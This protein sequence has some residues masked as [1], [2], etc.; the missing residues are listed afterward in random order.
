MKKQLLATLVTGALAAISVQPVSANNQM[1]PMIVVGTTPS[2]SENNLAG[3][4][5]SIS[6]DELAISHVDDTMELF[7]KVPGVY[8]ARYNQGIIN[9]D[10][11][12]RGFAAEGSTPHAK[13]LIDGIPANLHNGYSEMDQLFPANIDSVQVFK[14][15][16]DPRYGLHNVAGNYTI[17]TRTDLAREVELTYGSFNA[18]EVQAYAGEQT[19]NLQHSYFIGY[20][21]ADGYRDNE[22]LEKISA[23]GRWFYDFT[24][25]TRI[26]FIARV[27]EYDADAAGY[28]SREEARKHPTRSADYARLDG[29]D[30]QTQSFSLHFDHA[31]SDQLDWSVK[32][33]FNHYERE[34]WVRF[35]E[36]SDLQNRYD[37][38]DQYGVISTLNWQ[39]HPD[40]EVQWGVDAERQD[41]IEQRF[42]TVGFQRQRDS[43][44]VGRDYDYRFVSYGSYL[45]VSHMPVD[46]LAWNVALRG[47]RIRGEFTSTDSAGQKEQRNIY[48]FGTIVQPKAN[49]FLYPTDDV[50]LFVNVGRSFQHPLGASAYT[51]GNTSAR[52]V[53]L[54]DGW[55]AGVKW[56]LF[57]AL[58]L[59]ASYWEQKA[60]DEF[61]MIDGV[62]RNVGETLREGID[63]GFDWDLT[64]KVT[65]WGNIAGVDTEIQADGANKGNELRS[66]PDYTASLGLSYLI[67]PELTWRVHLD[68]QSGSY[69]NEENIGGQYGHYNLVNTSLDYLTDWGNINLQV[70]NLFNEYYEYVYDLGAANTV[71]T[72]HSPGNGINASVSVAYHF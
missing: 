13:L 68:S 5:D 59:R 54:N 67:L 21:E 36:A 49:L 39:V 4:V 35:S 65:L 18:K 24:D 20:R 53:S 66:I 16:S 52:D 46:W 17:N 60:S 22:Q 63:L 38:Q 30:K 57:D 3:S 40:W 62:P 23:S 10:I 11:G 6:R 28:L 69:V 64:E 58:Q 34:R 41:V 9:T 33:Y 55:E 37:D 15:N 70:N 27:A 42:G 71:D 43:S 1:S 14:G 44:A 47:D 8:F 56:R 26:G 29:G 48:D 19:G 12:I 7:S 50:T 32:S 45:Q 51:T 31:F 2:Y 72:I 61:V 25:D